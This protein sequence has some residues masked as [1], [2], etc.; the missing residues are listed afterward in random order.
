MKNSKYHPFMVEKARN[1]LETRAA[2]L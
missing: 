1:V 2:S